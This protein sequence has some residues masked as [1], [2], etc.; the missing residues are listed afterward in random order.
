MAVFT[1]N[2]FEQSFRAMAQRYRRAGIRIVCME[3]FGTD[4]MM[5]KVR[6][7]RGRLTGGF[8]IGYE[9]LDNLDAYRNGSELEEFFHMRMLEVIGDMLAYKNEKLGAGG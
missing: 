8:A 5:V 3:S 1:R 7:E 2:Q 6:C 4:A 9:M